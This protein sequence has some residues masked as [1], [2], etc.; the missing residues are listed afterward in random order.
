MT[1]SEITD[2][3]NACALAI[4][5]NLHYEIPA[6]ENSINTITALNKIII[7]LVNE[8]HVCGMV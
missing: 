8:Y 1:A 4:E 2:A 6:C 3:I 5:A 7:G